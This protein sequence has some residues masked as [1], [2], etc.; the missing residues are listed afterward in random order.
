MPQYKNDSR[1]IKL[2]VRV[3]DLQQDPLEVFKYLATKKIGLENS[4]YYIQYCNH[5]EERQKFD[6]ANIVY[7]SGIRLARNDKILKRYEEFKLRF[8]EYVVWSNNEAEKDVETSIR[9]RDTSHSNPYK[10]FDDFKSKPLISKMDVYKDTSEPKADSTDL[11]P[12]DNFYL[13]IDY[14][15][16]EKENKGEVATEWVNQVYKQQTTEKK[17]KKMEVYKDCE[18]ENHQ[19]KKDIKFAES[20][21]KIGEIFKTQKGN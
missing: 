8:S 6:E 16:S 7:E 11:L 9:L 1:Y 15:K 17:Q 4:E 12:F 3:A 5:L 2:W 13:N 19:M 18:D 10:I 20:E 14:S 21:V